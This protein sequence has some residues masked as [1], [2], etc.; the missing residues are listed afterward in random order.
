MCFSLELR[1]C[2]SRLAEAQAG[3]DR[4]SKI[5]VAEIMRK[6]DEG[7]EVWRHV[8][9][10]VATLD[11]LL[12][13]A[14]ACRSFG[15]CCFPEFGAD[16]CCELVQVRHP[17]LEKAVGCAGG[18]YIPNTIALAAPVSLITGPNSGGKSTVLRTVAVSSLLAQLG[19]KVPA[20]SARLPLV[21]RIFTRIGA[22]DDIMLGKSTFM[23]ELEETASILN[24]ATSKSLLILDELGRGTSTNDGYA[25]A[26]A[27]LHSLARL[28]ALTLF[29]THYHGLCADFR[30]NSN[31]A[32]SH[33]A[34]MTDEAA[35]DVVFL[36][37]LKSGP[38]GGSYGLNVA[39]MAG[40]PEEVIARAEA[41]AA[42]CQRLGMFNTNTNAATLRDWIRCTT[43][44]EARAMLDFCK[45]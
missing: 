23:V 21:D 9:R 17:V 7:Y 45:L 38:A 25:I 39:R 3:F 8:L 13:L 40:L 27:V 41:V 37:Q 32:Q 2:A 18:S 4:L 36:Y 42:E 29:A 5:A 34:F 12:S 10:S 20:A 14:N 31:V 26:W 44:E 1:K 35:R 43:K 33:V 11:C 19:C 15:E 28:K 16:G 22:R 24:Q 6:F 30:G